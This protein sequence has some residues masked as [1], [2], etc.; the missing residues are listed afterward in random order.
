MSPRKDTKDLLLLALKEAQKAPHKEE[1]WE[2]IEEMA[3]AQQ[4]PDEIAEVLRALV[5]ECEKAE[6]IDA[7]GKRAVRFHEEWFGAQAE[8]LVE[9]LTRVLEV[10]PGSDWALARL[11]V[12][13][14]VKERWTELLGLY[15]KA[16]GAHDEV[17]RRKELLGEAAHVARDFVGDI[18]RAIGYMGEQLRLFPSDGHLAAQIERLLERQGRWADLVK[19]WE[20]RLEVLGADERRGLRGRMASALLEKIG[21]AAGALRE[22]QAAV[23]DGAEESEGLVVDLLERILRLATAPV[24]IRWKALELLKLRYEA[25]GAVAK[26]VAVLLVTLEFATR[27]EKAGVHRE[28]AERLVGEG[29]RKGAVEHLVILM[30]LEPASTDVQGRLRHLAELEGVL[31]AYAR[32][33]EAA[34]G[35]AADAIRRQDLFLE[36]AR[37]HEDS[38]QDMRGAIGYFRKAH[39]ETE[40]NAVVRLEATRKLTELL[41]RDPQAEERRGER[42]LVLESLA[43]QL[44]ASAPTSAERRATL[45]QVARLGD[46]LGEVDRAAGAWAQRLEIDSA[47]RTAIDGLVDLLD[48]AKRWDLLVQALRRRSGLSS[49]A[50]QRRADLVRIATIQATELNV[51]ADAIDTWSE[52]LRTFGEDEAGVSTLA[53]LLTSTGRWAELGELLSRAGHRDSGRVA[54]LHARLGDAYRERL[55][56]PAR[57]VACYARAADLNPAH[58]EALAGLKALVMVEVSKAPA[59]E[60]LATAFRRTGEFRQERELLETRL[61]VA[62]DDGARV[63]LLL[64]GAV[65]EERRAEDPKAALALVAR[66]LPLGPNDAFVEREL[67]R[68]GSRAGEYAI[69]ADALK[70]AAVVVVQDSRRVAQLRFSEGALREAHLKDNAAALDAYREAFEREPGRSDAREA[71]LRTAA[72]VGRWDLVGQLLVAQPVLRDPLERTFLPMV[73][74]L[75]AD[76]GATAELAVA[77]DAAVNVAGGEGRLEAALARDLLARAAR[78]HEAAGGVDRAESALARAASYAR[79]IREGIRDEGMGTSAEALAAA[80]LPVLRRLAELQRRSPGR[81]LYETLMVLADLVPGDLDALVEAA[82]LALGPLVAENQAQTVLGR[83]LDQ[84]A[85]LLR[86]GQGAAGN[87]KADEAAA[88]AVGELGRLLA[89]RPDRGG[90]TRAVE[91]LLDGTRLPVG[92]DTV[93]SLR[94][95]AIEIALEK[96]KDRRVAISVLR[97]VVDDDFNDAA[98]V[99]QLGTLYE[100]EKRFPELLTLIKEELARTGSVDR[101]L[102]L[103]LDME[104]IAA[105]LEERSGRVETLKANLE[106]QP[107]HEA[108]IEILAGV[109]EAKVRHAELGEVLVDQARRLEERDDRE[110]AARLW[111]RAARLIETRL[112]DPARAATAFERVAELDPRPEAFEALGRLVMAKGDALGAAAWMEKWLASAPA[113]VHT[114]AALRLSQA[115]QQADRRHRAVACL[116]RA[117]GEAPA[118]G[119]VRAALIDLYRKA[120]AWEPLV[121]TL[122]EGCGHLSNLETIV[123]YAREAAE[124]AEA[125]LGSLAPA[126]SA[127]E[128]AATMAP[129]DRAMRTTF[130]DAL[131]VSGDLVRAREVLQEL[132]KESGRRRSRERAAVH[133]RLA[134][135]ARG[136]GN[137][138]EALENLDQAAEMDMDNA[139]VLQLTGEVAAEAGNL[140]RA[141]RAYRSLILLGRREGSGATL[142]PGEVLLRLR[143]IAMQR[144]QTDKATDLLDSIISEALQSKTEALRIQ[145]ALRAAGARTELRTVLEK[146]LAAAGDDQLTQAAALAELADL[147]AAEGRAPEALEALLGSLEKDPDSVAR[148]A[149]AREIAQTTKQSDKL[150]ASL[151]LA[152]EQRRRAGDATLVARLCLLAGEVSEYDLLDRDRAADFYGK[153]GQSGVEAG[154]LAVRAAAGLLRVAKGS[155]ER[156]KAQKVLAR[157]AGEGSPKEVRIEALYRTAEALL[158][159][160]DTRD[161]GLEALSLALEVEPD[162]ERAFGLVRAAKVSD[163]ELAKVLPLYERVARASGDDHMLLDFL[164][165]RAGLPAS[166]ADEVKEAVDLAMALNDRDRAEAMLKRTVELLKSKEDAP[167]KQL[168]WAYLELAQL[169]K[170]A[171]DVAGAITWLEEAR[172]VGDPVRILRYFQEIAQKALTGVGDPAVAARVYERLWERE[173]GERRYWEPLLSL[174]GRLKDRVAA[175]RVARATLEK[176][177]TPVERNLVR[178]AVVRLLLELDPK[179]KSAEEILRD[180]LTE[181]PADRDALALLADIYQATGNAEGLRDLLLREIEAAKER[182]DKPAVIEL[183]LR[184]GKQ[185]LPEHVADAREVYRQALQL[186]PDSAEL[187]GALVALLSP[188]D[189]GRERAMLLERLLALST[190]EEAALL[191]LELCDLW[192]AL[193][194]E[195]RV[196]MALE[197][198]RKRAPDSRPLFER[199]CDLYRERKAWAPLAGLLGEA[200][201]STPDLSLRVARLREAA[202]IYRQTLGQPA[203][204]AA[205]LRLA[206]D[207]IPHDSEILT[208]LIACLEAAGDGA[209]AIEEVARAITSSQAGSA[210]HTELCRLNAQLREASGD[211][212]G[213]VADLEVAFSADNGIEPALRDLLERARAAAAGRA[214]DDTERRTM[215]RLVQLHSQAGEDELARAA[216][217]EWAWRH[218]KDGEVLRLLKNRD[219]AAGRWDEVVDTCN[220]LV[221]IEVGS[222]RLAAAQSLV[223]AADQVGR[224]GRAIPGLEAY[225]K[226]E[227]DDGFAFGRLMKLYDASGEPQKQAELLMWS[228]ARDADPAARFESLRRAGDIFLRERIVSSATEA[229]GLAL[230]IR[231][232]DRDLALRLA[233]TQIADGRLAEADQILQNLMKTVGKDMSSAELSSLQ[234]RLAQLSRAQGDAT[235][236]LDW[237]KKAFDTNR[238]NADVAIELADVAESID[239]FDLAV[240]ALRAITLLPASGGMSPAT[241]F[242]RQARIAMRTGDKPRAVIFAKRALQEDPRLGDAAEFLKD[243]GERR[244]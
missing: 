37:V 138:V 218:P 34:A 145:A 70:A 173:P 214:D 129:G 11:T 202:D 59:A 134:K 33:L 163:A 81:P 76:A 4:R 84:A 212:D 113:E 169:R 198:G 43:A 86:L 123:A 229:F 7:L 228:A 210:H 68:L 133:L 17:A 100:E 242:F 27:E 137:A 119:D 192:G 117:L 158:P 191:A 186:A 62:A 188:E 171:G 74:G 174:Y 190:G 56:D 57:A 120:Q 197:M 105:A 8:A 28:V 45:G 2:K 50:A 55:G 153:A 139:V 130:A 166:T 161:K 116:E 211:L 150:L 182:K 155:A 236:H 223:A 9:I 215:T 12:L 122:S 234:H 180:V 232:A 204:A 13:F 16:L 235:A 79:R 196:G 168:E 238:K 71:A 241:A 200:A 21:D 185:L 151:Q 213:A 26:I 195:K 30:G 194:D 128:K 176:V 175:E 140:D 112:G 127:V 75:A 240:K 47:D 149:Q 237:L 157:M 209:G 90:W 135:V 159:A 1:I 244:P 25:G 142:S 89:G 156:A 88:W 184:M 125:R 58:L 230:Q 10:D 51:A 65:L 189:E 201:A 64:E 126:L 63:R 35:A 99:A 144:G 3:A 208:E 87:R 6:L 41:A 49:P 199:L 46:E 54:D 106:D 170:N 40:G 61:E 177:F 154:E 92:R 115:Y 103:R 216:L 164:A 23:A 109:L 53:D 187:L 193:D 136:Q 18:D 148:Y 82:E 203:E 44:G 165:R 111:L 124:V 132:L 160:E 52:I 83:V 38:L 205:L 14:T 231:P 102:V 225:L 178:M 152:I 179:D 217:A 207:A 222:D 146:R 141:E 80:E 172:E 85:R 239:D 77:M 121:R 110:G 108:T 162:V 42:L 97:Q 167:A 181:E 220:R 131:F 143:G 48:R 22:L 206:R 98:A 226:A 95:R 20:S 73:Q 233:E 69:A 32:G 36:A 60:A 39:A 224:P 72:Q 66:A 96:L 78:L 93:R 221:Q 183:S 24:P 29:D 118:S 19:L 94:Q 67:L 147:H 5:K 104:K 91:L 107:G 31:P 101:R 219:E 15:D 243:L 114:H 227:P